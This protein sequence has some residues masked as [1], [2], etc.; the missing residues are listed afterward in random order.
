MDNI[1]EFICNIPKAELHLHIE[2]T[3]EPE[4]MFEI[5]A[6]NYITIEYQSIEELRNA[7]K[8][9][10]LQEF[11]DIYYTGAYVL[12]TEKDFYEL[13]MAYLKKAAGQ[14]IVHTEIF[15]DPQ[16]HLHNGVPFSV[17]FNGIY[18]A[19]IDAEKQYSIHTGLIMCFLRHLS[20]KSAFD[21]LEMSLPY[22]DKILGVG[23]DSSE[24]GNP[25]EKFCRVFE[26]ARQ[27]GFLAVAHAGEEGPA[28]YIHEALDL[29]KIDR[30]DH[31][32]NSKDSE[33]LMDEIA[34][35]K[36]P[37][38]MC[39]LSNLKLAVVKDLKDHPLRKFLDKNIAVTINSD[40]PAYFGGYLNENLIAMQKALNL[41]FDDII[42][43]VKNSF[44]AS[45]IDKQQ[46]E[47]YL[48][49]VDDFVAEYFNT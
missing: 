30:I 46:K 41:T 28:A 1:S 13:T 39:P 8:F 6:R 31:G 4:Q 45:F 5:A 11:L 25:P 9:N 23:L 16:T 43:L 22:K 38:T 20:E 21:T 40:D 34:R 2:G 26:K 44:E 27:Y 47:N 3:F 14:N 12:Q 32:N 48:Q 18:K 33:V 17:F 36:I 29:L 37:L 42:I 10:N 49:L 35:K 19:V 7:Y 24:V 15:F